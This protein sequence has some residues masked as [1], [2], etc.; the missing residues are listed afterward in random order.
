MV[1][2][3]GQAV[4]AFVT[5]SGLQAGEQ[6]VLDASVRAGDRVRAGPATAPRAGSG[7][8]AAAAVTSMGR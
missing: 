8:G 2:L 3:R 1:G 4:H 5:Q 7:E 6:V